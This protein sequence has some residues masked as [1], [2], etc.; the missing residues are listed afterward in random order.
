MTA[1][2][3]ILIVDDSKFLQ[4]V[5]FDRLMKEGYYVLQAFTGQQGL[6]MAH[7]YKPDLIILDIMLPGGLNGF[8][9]LEQMRRDMSLKD[10]PI[11]M[12]TDLNNE[13]KTAQS[14]GATDYIIKSSNVADDLVAKIE[15]HLKSD[16]VDKIKK[17][18]K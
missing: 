15:L 1:G 7:S 14:L 2:K 13:Q 6:T 16:I 3:K 18:L 8:D 9:V 4:Q 5:Y 12:L 11:I 17:I 10:I